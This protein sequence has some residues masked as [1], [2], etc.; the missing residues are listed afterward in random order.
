MTERG[1]EGI[2]ADKYTFVSLPPWAAKIELLQ[3]LAFFLGAE[4]GVDSCAADGALTLEG[5]FTVLHGNPLWVLHLS[6]CFA[7]DTIILISHGDVAS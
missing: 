1:R 2:C 6:F 3:V 5:W 7:L 4:N